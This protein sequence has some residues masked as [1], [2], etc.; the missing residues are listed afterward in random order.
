MVIELFSV[1][2]RRKPEEDI[3][4]QGKERLKRDENEWKS[5]NEAVQVPESR[6]LPL[7]GYL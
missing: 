4:Q 1:V 2:T 7:E 3:E 6:S 5:G